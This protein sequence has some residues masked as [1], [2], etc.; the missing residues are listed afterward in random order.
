[1]R[2]CA[3]SATK[4]CGTGTASLCPVGDGCQTD[5]DCATDYCGDGSRCAAPG[6]AAFSDNRRNAGETDVDCGG[7]SGKACAAGGK[8]KV[9][10]DCVG[11]CSA[12]TCGAVGDADG[13]KN[14]GETDVDCK[15]ATTRR[16]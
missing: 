14:N 4:T 5:L 15:L 10:G 12:G 6:P 3:A 9:A 11:A 1:M 7:A 8:C 13:K 16:L 2:T